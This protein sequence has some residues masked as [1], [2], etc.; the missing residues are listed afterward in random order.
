MRKKMSKHAI[1]PLL[2][3]FTLIFTSFVWADSENASFTAKPEGDIQIYGDSIVW[4]SYI[5]GNWDIY[6]MDKSTGVETRITDN[7]NTQGYP[8][9]WQ[10]YIVWQDDR[11]YREK[12][13]DGFD[14]YLYDITSGQEKKISNAEGNHQYPIISDNKVVWTDNKDGQK[15]IMLYDIE[16]EMLDKV[17]SDGA[18][19]FGV[20]FDGQVISW[21]DTRDGD[22]DIY[23]YD[24][25]EKVEKQ[26]TYGLGDELDPMVRDGK[27]VWMVAHN[28]ASQ[29]YMYEVE[30][31]YT[32]K[33]T[34]ENE[35]HRPIAFSGN[36]LLMEQGESLV[37]GDVNR[38]TGQPVKPPGGIIPK[39]A[40]LSEGEVI[41][42]DGR[43]ITEEEVTDAVN[44]ALIAEDNPEEPQTP[45]VSESSSGQKDSDKEVT[46]T[47]KLVR[48]DADTIITSEDGRMTL[49]ISKG[50]FDKDVYI[51]INTEDKLKAEGYLSVTPVYRWSIGGNAKLLKPL[52]ISINYK[53]IAI[54]GSQKKICLYKVVENNTPKPITSKIDH[55]TNTLA[56]EVEYS[57]EAALLIYDRKFTD[58]EK[59]WA[60]DIVEIIASHHIIN[61]YQD[62]GFKPDREISRAEF[63]KILISS[64]HLADKEAQNSRKSA[65]QDVP[66]SYWAS[67][68]I[69][70]AYEKGWITGYDGRFNPDSPITR[71]QMAAILMRVYDDISMHNVSNKVEK[72]SLSGF[73][74][75]D[76]IST[77]ALDSMKK[78]VELGIINGYNGE[79]SPR[80]N[81]TRAEAAA[82][83][84][85]YLEILGRI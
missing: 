38:I 61:G 85:R 49:K 42:Y 50:S 71:E 68:Y 17:S 32:T 29:I 57:G 56:G 36:S 52:E 41:W 30:N 25:Y 10:N 24:I 46:N 22:F 9:V 65:F 59:H 34:V 79:I 13:I 3:L 14:I 5:R 37:L 28:G 55:K 73:A 21:M 58:I 8:D 48:A 69:N 77:W 76:K 78:A 74:D 60:Y 31:G 1:L 51:T 20:D 81:A 64:L 39:Q 43:K 45:D 63:V 19:A 7:P 66:D 12:G 80:D 4:M 62:G 11:E 18:E 54:N 67:D 72:P 6:H 2:L 16:S 70:A 15:N 23:M 33:L 44:R 27:V 53:D 84:Y 35:N 75:K 26:L 47:G 83:L 82:M 40:F